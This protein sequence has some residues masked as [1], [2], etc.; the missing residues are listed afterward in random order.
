MMILLLLIPFLLVKE[1][2]ITKKYILLLLSLPVLVTFYLTNARNAVLGLFTGLLLIGILKNRKFLLGLL[3]LTSLFLIFAPEG[4]KD[5]A[6]SIGDFKHPSNVTRFMIWETGIK[7][8]K[9]SPFIGY[10]EVDFKEIYSRYRDPKRH[11]EGS[12][13]HNSA[14]QIMVNSGL[15]GFLAWFLLML[16]IFL[17]QI[18]IFLK[19]KQ[20]EFLNILAMVSAV[21]MIS[22]QICGLTEWNFGDAE[23]AA[24]FWFNLSLAFIADKFSNS[25]EAEK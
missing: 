22:L 9:D 8:I 21:S 18:K 24:V 19:T 12:H 6:L 23:F 11:G 25:K 14:L 17:N 15:L 7:I 3:T 13:M 1:N 4:I 20:H 10:G 2:F 16:Y 5:R